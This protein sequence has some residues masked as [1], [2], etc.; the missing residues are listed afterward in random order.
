MQEN[1]SVSDLNPMNKIKEMAKFLLIC[2]LKALVAGFVIYFVMAKTGLKDQASI[3]NYLIYFI[4]GSVV[5][6]L[7]TFGY[8]A[9]LC[10]SDKFDAK[11]LA[12]LSI[13]GPSIVLTH[14]VIL[15]VS[16]LIVD[17]PEV[18]LVVYG[19]VWS[20]FGIVLITGIMYAIGLT[21]AEKTAS[22]ATL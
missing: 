19:I 2:L 5:M 21:V 22:C 7:V 12:K 14:V 18:G 9:Y 8:F 17:V 11:K 16:S 10:R 1:F 13:L 20:S 4:V 6:F 15:V 3:K